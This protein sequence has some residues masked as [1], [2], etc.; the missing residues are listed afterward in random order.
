M[1]FAGHGLWQCRDQGDAREPAL[2][3][4]RAGLLLQ[5]R[6]IRA[7][8]IGSGEKVGAG[9]GNRTR[10]ASLEGWSFTIKLYP[11]NERIMFKSRDKTSFFSLLRQ[12]N[13]KRGYVFSVVLTSGPSAAK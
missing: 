7:W 10:I 6:P 3:G 5:V 11:R 4:G 9:S 2:A 13:K 1:Q 8:N 12:N